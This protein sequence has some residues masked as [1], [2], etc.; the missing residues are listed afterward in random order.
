MIYRNDV[1]MPMTPVSANQ[2]TEPTC[3]KQLTY[4]HFFAMNDN[5]LQISKF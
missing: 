4:V 5:F 1:E 3:D 2:K